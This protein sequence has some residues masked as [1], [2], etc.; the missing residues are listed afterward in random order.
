MQKRRRAACVTGINIALKACIDF[1]AQAGVYDALAP[2]ST[3]GD[4]RHHGVAMRRAAQDQQSMHD[5]ADNRFDRTAA[6][7]NALARLES[8]ITDHCAHNASP[9]TQPYTECKGPIYDCVHADAPENGP[10]QQFF[11]FRSLLRAA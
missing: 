2:R 8:G 4:G 5:L 11:T 3:S 9:T 6:R 10:G 1:G 7:A